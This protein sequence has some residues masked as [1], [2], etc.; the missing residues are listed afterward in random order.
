MKSIILIIWI[1][2]SCLG[3]GQNL[4]VNGNWEAS[5]I[6]SGVPAPWLSLNPTQVLI[7]DLTNSKCGNINNGDGTIY[8]VFDVTP[9]LTYNVAF[10][11]RWVSGG[12]SYNMTA[13]VK[14]GATGGND[15]GTIV[16]NSTPDI[17]YNGTFS[18]TVPAGVTSTR[19]IF[20]KTS[21]NRPLRID[22]VYV[23]EQD[24]P[25]SN[26]ID[27]N[28]PINA[29]PVGVSGSWDLDFSDEFNNNTINTSKWIISESSSSRA[30]RPNLGVTDW[31][32]KKENA[33]LD[34][35]GNLVLRG[36][37]VDNNTMFCGSVESRNIYEPTYGYLEA[38]L[39]IA[40]TSKGNHT[41]FWLQGHNQ[42]NVD[43]SAA[44]GAEVDIFES[45][46]ITND[47]KAVVH[48]DGYG[49]QRKNHTI[50][51]NTPN[52][53]NGYHT[54]GLHWTE[55]AMDIYYDGVKVESTNNSKPF[56]FTLDPNGYSV[57]PQVPEWLWL[58]VG[59]S[60]GD[61]DFQSQ[62][63]GTLSDALVDYVRVYKPA[64]TLGFQD[65]T[66][67]GKFVL[68]PNPAQNIVTIKSKED[69]YTIQVFD[70]NGRAMMNLK[71]SE[72]S[73]LDVSGFA[74]GIYIIKIKS[75][76]VISNYKI[77]VD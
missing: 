4:I 34:G 71:A 14:D 40:E 75:N 26:F 2:Y 30:P 49:A 66:V 9:E 24:S 44:D 72:T 13:R 54:F 25:S 35:S 7:D 46:W 23:V 57:V 48:F 15:L 10:N 50:P 11:Y 27:S 37:K 58:S 60:F 65:N 31:W 51:F 20:Y 61:G 29:Q 74:T 32:W 28:T 52:L 41:S 55:N 19:I 76:K 42:G 12:G 17:W 56:P 22:N 62:P 21:G 33:F 38:R 59:A 18:F 16:L 43:N 53:H 70:L 68:F 63:I 64:S 73:T 77:I 1:L 8:Q 6:M 47:T 67:K 36:T 5:E 39:Q 45:A 3:F 69:N